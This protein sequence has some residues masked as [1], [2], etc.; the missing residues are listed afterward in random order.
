MKFA[1]YLGR[2]DLA[3]QHVSEMINKA[4]T[5]QELI[6][7]HDKEGIAPFLRLRLVPRWDNDPRR[8]KLVRDDVE[9]LI[10]QISD[11]VRKKL[12]DPKNIQL[13]A[14]NLYGTPEENAFARIALANSG[15]LAAL[16]LLE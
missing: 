4:P 10:K 3:S 7:V 5:E 14:A 15:A 11:A 1:M 16:Y 2:F 6:D 8:D 13:Y 9:S 12:A